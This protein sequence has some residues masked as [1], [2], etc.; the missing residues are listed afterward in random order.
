MNPI[1]QL[2]RFAGSLA[3]LAAALLAFAAAAPAA[4]ASGRGPLPPPPIREKHPPLPPGH[5]HQPVH[6]VP[7]HT[8]VAGGMP[9]WQIALIAIGAALAAATVAILVDRAW[10][11]RRKPL[12]PAA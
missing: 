1:R 11:A 9:G 3:G 8:V 5:I 7:V 12:T 6:Q 10:A 4:L 2:R